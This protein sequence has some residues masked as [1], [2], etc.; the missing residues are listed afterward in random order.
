MET[1][2]SFKTILWVV[3]GLLVIVVGVTLILKNNKKTEEEQ[4]FVINEASVEEVSISLMESFPVKV[5]VLAKGNLPDGC[6]QI[7]DVDQKYD[8]GVFDLTLYTKKPLD[9][10]MC[11]QALVPFEESI[12]LSGVVGLTKGNYKVIVNGIEAN[13]KLDIDN[14]INES[15]PLK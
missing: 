3:L 11:T 14:F 7:G 15:D 5:N 4:N 13:F 12:E 6:T 9:S 2:N 10:K 8:K 1:N